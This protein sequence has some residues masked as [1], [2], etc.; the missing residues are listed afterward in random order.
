MTNTTDPVGGFLRRSQWRPTEIMVWV[1][2]IAAFFVFPDRLVL[3]SRVLIIAIYALSLD[4]LLGYGGLISL[5]HAAYFGTGAY[6]AGLIANYGWT[7]PISGLIGAAVIAGVLGYLAGFIIVRLN[8]VALL[9][10]TLGFGLLI[11]ELAN[12]L[13]D[14]TGGSDGLNMTFAPILG[15]FDFDLAGQ[16]AYI[17]SAAFALLAFVFV[18]RIVNSPFG[19][20]L[21]GYRENPKRMAQIGAPMA[22]RLRLVNALA[23]AL[24][25]LAGGLLTQ[26]NQFVGLDSVGFERSADTLIMLI[27]GGGGRLYGGLVGA[28]VFLV[29]RDVFSEANPQ[30]WYFWL[31]LLLVLIVLFMPQGIL[32][33][34]DA[35]LAR[36]KR[37]RKAAP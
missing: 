20:S 18:R 24:A 25:G 31:G 32:G 6:A 2:V 28:L 4:L 30:Y 11:S 7:E 9:M 26:T 29:G 33:G 23:A 5:G 12:S 35:L 34:I 10:V 3:G 15:H 22:A 37:M 36:I 27:L 8:G 17:Y 21:Q 19:L 1:L 13:N 14:I 16:T